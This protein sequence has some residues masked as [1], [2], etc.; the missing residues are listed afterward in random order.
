MKII[1]QTEKM[2]RIFNSPSMQIIQRQ[3]KRCEDLMGFTSAIESMMQAQERMKQITAPLE[4]LYDF[5]NRMNSIEYV[6]NSIPNI[7]N[8]F[9][10]GIVN[11]NEIF[12]ALDLLK[13][14]ERIKRCFGNSLLYK[15]IEEEI[16]EIPI[17]NIPETFNNCIDWEGFTL[18]DVDSKNPTLNNQ[19][20][21]KCNE[22]HE[23]IKLFLIVFLMPLIVNILSNTIYDNTIAK[24]NKIAFI[25][26][27]NIIEDYFVVESVLN[28]E[29][30][31][32]FVGDKVIKPRVKPDCSSAVV[33]NLEPGRVVYAIEKKKKWIHIL[34]KNE[35]GEECCG[36]IQNWKLEYL[37][38]E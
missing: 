18:S 15:F 32:F 28:N 9:L 8:N 20:E 30:R 19:V 37:I 25:S 31:I 1:E 7:T 12:P 16:R 24:N 17:D 11:C 27:E 13:D 33:G 38:L 3:Q 2:N 29:N 26:T 6:M 21:G 5:N 4:G 22:K 35:K 14:A 10:V 23:Y 36:W 34:W